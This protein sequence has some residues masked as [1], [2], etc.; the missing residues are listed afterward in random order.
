M[1]SVGGEYAMMS[2]IGGLQLASS[3]V[4]SGVFIPTPLPKFTLIVPQPF[5]TELNPW[6]LYSIFPYGAYVHT[7]SSIL[8][9]ITKLLDRSYTLRGNSS[10]VVIE[11]Y[12]RK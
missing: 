1:E 10:I 11:C 8:M 7:S 4:S 9:N 12:W 6:H 5:P 3:A 2:P